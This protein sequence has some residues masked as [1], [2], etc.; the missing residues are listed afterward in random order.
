ML[1]HDF[2]WLKSCQPICLVQ[3]PDLFIT[4]GDQISKLKQCCK[5]RRDGQ[6]CYTKSLLMKNKCYSKRTGKLCL[7]AFYNVDLVYKLPGWADE[8]VDSTVRWNRVI[9][10]F[11]VIDLAGGNLWNRHCLECG[12]NQSASRIRPTCCINW[13]KCTFLLT[14]ILFV[15]FQHSL[16]LEPISVIF[17]SWFQ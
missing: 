5:Y 1:I 10:H 6:Q 2:D 15:M 7:D 13:I 11:H 12:F 9:K 17:M 8:T 3:T 14:I 16:H 4:I